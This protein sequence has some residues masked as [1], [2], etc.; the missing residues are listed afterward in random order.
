MKTGAND[1]CPCG[2]GNKYK[3]CC[4]NNDVTPWATWR[5][6]AS[7][8]AEKNGLDNRLAEAFCTLLKL[9][10]NYNW[11]GACHGASA[12]LYVIFNELG[13][14]P[15]LCA[16]IVATDFWT[17]GHS[18]IELNGKVYDVSC[19]FPN[20]GTAKMMPVFHGKELDSNNDI[21]TQYGVSNAPIAKDVEMVMTMEVSNVMGA[22][23][24]EVGNANLWQV[25]ASVCV[26]A[27]IEIPLIDIRGNTMDASKIAKKYES[28]KWELR[29]SIYL[30]EAHYIDLRP[31]N[32]R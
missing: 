11:T 31:E 22:D 29:N 15:K 3:R 9:I 27:K 16:G 25:L 24:E 8:M 2:S 30:P 6:N 1:P 14:E 20:I 7:K 26:E 19:Y 10:S 21:V 5:N 12:I 13:Y 17:S 4:R 28:V 18:W 32:L 23:Y